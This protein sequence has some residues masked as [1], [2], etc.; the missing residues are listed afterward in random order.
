[1]IK[2]KKLF[3]TAS[4]VVNLI[5]CQGFLER[6]EKFCFCP[7]LQNCSRNATNLCVRN[8][9]SNCTLLRN[10]CEVEQARCQGQGKYL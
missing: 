6:E 2:K 4:S 5:H 10:Q 8:R 9:A 7:N 1:M 3:L